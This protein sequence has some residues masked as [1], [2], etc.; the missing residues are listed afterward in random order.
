MVVTPTGQMPVSSV[1]INYNYKERYLL[2]INGRYDGS[3]RFIG[4]KRWGF[5]PSFSAG[6]NVS[7]EP[8]WR[9]LEHIVNNF[10]IRGSWGELGNCNT[11]AFY[12]F[13]QTM[14]TGVE[15]SGWLIRKET[16]YSFCTGHCEC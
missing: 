12:P 4:D 7:R 14:P 1:C 11:T 15:N 5:F 2:E 3:S 16:E 9:D 8:F 10:K 6:W 13:Y